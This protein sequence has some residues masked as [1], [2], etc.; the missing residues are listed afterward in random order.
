MSCLTDM[1]ELKWVESQLRQRTADVERREAT[2][3]T[4]PL[5]DSVS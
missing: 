2:S 3:R 5:L 4:T 1:S